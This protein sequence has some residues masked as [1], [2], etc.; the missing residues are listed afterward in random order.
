MQRL[1]FLDTSQAAQ[2]IAEIGRR[3][4]EARGGVP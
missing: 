2:Q 1:R 3:V 4:G